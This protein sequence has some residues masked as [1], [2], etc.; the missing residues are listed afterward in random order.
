MLLRKTPSS[1][2]TE[3]ASV[4]NYDIE[5]NDFE[6]LNK[7][8]SEVLELVDNLSPKNK[9]EKT[10]KNVVGILGKHIQILANNCNEMSNSVDNVEVDLAKTH[11]Y[12]RRNTLVVT[13]LEYKKET[14]T[15][16]TLSSTVADELTTSGIKVNSNDFFP[17]HKL[18]A[19]RQ[20]KGLGVRRIF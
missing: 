20:W 8:L 5:L 19:K 14:E 3:K 7:S 12:S 6:T 9:F 10:I 16:D 17:A 13:G 18:F 1:S 2:K 4:K 11:Q 15:Y